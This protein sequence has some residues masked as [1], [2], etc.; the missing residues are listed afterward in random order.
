MAKPM[1]LG[2]TEPVPAGPVEK[3]LEWQRAPAAP[4][5]VLPGGDFQAQE[6]RARQLQVN[7]G[8]A[9]D[10]HPDEAAKAL[11]YSRDRGMDFEQGEREIKLAPPPPQ[12]DWGAL[13]RDHPVLSDYLSDTGRAAAARDDVG[14]LSMLEKLFG[15]WQ[16]IGWNTVQGW[17]QGRQTVRLAEIGAREADGT[18][19]PAEIAEADR[20]EKMGVQTVDQGFVPGIPGAAAQA[21]P[22][23]IDTFLKSGKEVSVGA[24][25]GVVAGAIAG[26]PAGGVGAIPG[27]A[28][29][30]LSGAGLGAKVGMTTAMGR[31]E[32]GL[33]FREYKQIPGVDLNTAR[34]A[35]NVVGAINGLLEVLP[36][37]KVLQ[38]PGLKSLFSGAGPRDW[39]R[40]LVTSNTGR[41]AVVRAAMRISEGALIDGI[42]EA[43]QEFTTML[44]GKYAGD[45]TP[46][47]PKR[48]WDSFVGGAQMAIGL[49]AAGVYTGYRGEKAEAKAGSDRKGFFEAIGQL[50]TDSKLRERMPE[51]YKAYANSLISE[52]GKIDEA[53]APAGKLRE[54]FQKEGISDEELA[55]TMPEVARQ[56]AE[57]SDPEA[58]ITIPMAD[59][60]TNI[61][62]LKGYATLHEDLR[63]KEEPTAREQKE[64]KAEVDKMLQE[65]KKPQAENGP[66]PLPGEKVFNDLYTKAI[67]SGISERSATVYA[68][69]WR[70]FAETRAAK[71]GKNAF[72]YY[73]SRKLEITNSDVI[74]NVIPEDTKFTP[75]QEKLKAAALNGDVQAL[76]KLIEPFMIDPLTGANTKE[77]WNRFAPQDD[78]GEFVNPP[79]GAYISIDANDLKRVNDT[80]GGHGAGNAFLK[81]LAAAVGPAVRENRGKF[82]RSGGDEFMAHFRTPAEA[83]KAEAAIRAAMAAA[84]SLKLEGGEHR[85]SVTLGVGADPKSADA[86]GV[87]A[88]EEA[89]AAGRSGFGRPGAVEKADYTKGDVFSRF[90]EKSLQAFEAALTAGG[91][92]ELHQ[93]VDPTETPAF[94]KWFKKSKVVDADGNPLIV[95]HGTTHGFD[96]FTKDRGNP[97]NWYGRA[98]YFTDSVED[99]NANYA[100]EGPD[101]TNRI[102]QRAEQIANER[103]VQV[104]SDEFDAITEEARKEL[105]GE[106][107]SV[108][109]VYV[110][111]QNPVIV[112]SRES[113]N[114]S[115]HKTTQLE[116]TEKFEEGYED[117]PVYEGSGM[118]VVEAI[119]K[120]GLQYRMDGPEEL[121]NDIFMKIFEGDGSAYEIEKFLRESEKVTYLEGEEGG[122]VGNEFIRDVWEAA[123]FDGAIMGA[124][125]NFGA[126]RGAGK[127]MEGINED[128][129]HY[130]AFKPT[131]IK[132]AIGNSGK[133]SSRSSNILKQK[134]EEV[135]RGKINFDDARRWF[136]ITLTG[137]ANLSTFLHESGHAFLEFLRVDAQEGD[138]ASKSELDVIAKWL[139]KENID[140]LS[141]DDLEK[142]ARG[143]ESYLMEGKAPSTKLGEVF[144]T[145]SD[146][147][148]YIY[149]TLTGLN[150]E[151]TDEVRGVFDRMLATEEEITTARESM[152][153]VPDPELTKEKSGYAE[154]FSKAMAGAQ[155]EASQAAARELRRNLTDEY[156]QIVDDVREMVKGDRAYN[157]WE[158]LSG[159]PRLDGSEFVAPETLQGKRKL[160]RA[161][162]TE[163]GLSSEENRRIRTLTE[164]GGI[165]PESIAPMLGYSSGEE[166]V[167]ELAGL[168]GRARFEKAEADR[169]MA[170]RYPAY[171]GKDVRAWIARKARTVL[172]A[173]PITRLLWDEATAAGEAVYTKG[174]AE[175]DRQ[176][177]RA[178]AKSEKEMQKANETINDLTNVQGE[179]RAALGVGA[180]IRKAKAVL[181]EYTRR[182]VSEM[183]YL[184]MQPG[185]F[186][187]AEARHAAEWVKAAKKG[188][189]AAAYEAKMEQIRNHLMWKATERALEEI[190]AISNRMRKIQ[191][192][193]AQRK[194]GKAGSQYREGVNAILEG[195]EFT[196]KSQAAVDRQISLEMFVKQMED[197]GAVINIPPEIRA[198]VGLKNY[199]RM[200]L[201]ELRAISDS[202]ANIEA[203]ARLKN[204]LFDGRQ[205][206]DFA[207]TSTKLAE[208]IKA[209]VGAEYGDKPGQKQNPGWWEEKRGFFRTA[210]ANLLKIEFLARHLDGGETAGW[211]HELLFQPLVDAQNRKRK[212]QK[213]ITQRITAPFHE[214]S[215]AD[216]MRYDRYVDFL[217]YKLRVRE[218]I[219]LMLNLG[220]EGNR[221]KIIDG[222]RYRGWTE[223]AIFKKL[224]E[225]HAAG[226]ITNKDL[227]LVEHIW[228][229]IDE[230]WPHI[231]AL[232]ERVTGV[233]PPRVEPLAFEIA[234]RTMKGGY[235]PIVYD[236][237]KSHKG[238][239][240]AQRKTGDLFENNFLLPAVEKGFTESRT[241]F[242]APIALTLDVVP[243]HV[244]EVIH[245]LTHYEAVRAV[246]RLTSSKVVREA[247]TEGVG[248]E[249]YN[250][251]RPWLQ[252]IAADGAIHENVDFVDRTLRRLRLGSSIAILGFKVTTG[253]KQ[254]YGLSTTTKEIGIKYTGVGIEQFMDRLMKGEPFKEIA[255]LSQE[256]ADLEMQHDRDIGQMFERYT[257]AFSEFGHMKHQLARFSLSWMMLN[258]KV[259]NAVT[260][261]GAREKATVEGHPDPVRYADAIVRMSQ[262]GGGVKDLAQIQRGSETKRMFV[263]MY[264]YFSVLANQLGEPL[265]RTA[266]A[267]RKATIMAARW[268]WLVTLPVLLDLGKKALPK[269]D[270]DPEDYALRM[271]RE[272]ALYAGRTTPLFGEALD[273]AFSEREARYGAW[274]ATMIKGAAAA[275]KSGRAASLTDTGV[276]SMV[277]LLGAAGGLPTGAAMNAYRFLDEYT[278]GS[279]EEPVQDI[280]FRSPSEWE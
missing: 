75:E 177:K 32:K 231:K 268:W 92:K 127:P 130:I 96:S 275:G 230:L 9:F 269:D 262:S 193:S 70:A 245:Y 69:V 86:A 68:H 113:E 10:R 73:S 100:G 261:L 143:F 238:E 81:Q 151:L 139:G 145:V 11:R 250:S 227:D 273:A 225:L 247:L 35:A 278:R 263:V 72:D 117:E 160:S 162:V 34:A 195:V 59:L 118:K 94:K 223:E 2:V 159:R 242:A 107:P 45:Q 91:G 93:K 216:R 229:T 39:V 8:F 265:P 178:A 277:E 147:M 97:E 136:R 121:A 26:A 258:Q 89:R 164:E 253:L 190:D 180:E 48:V 30:L 235:Y 168:Q 101:L 259:V 271:L 183:S 206:R 187:R 233:A 211:T 174:L 80:L 62:P 111:L 150:V 126:G 276:R 71:L 213:E 66:P 110:A 21:L 175:K 184:E 18:A 228:K 40:K 200:T 140:E 270:E 156:K 54:L 131:Q 102:V 221:T 199:K 60:A 207:I 56:L 198:G 182:R 123:G 36:I 108:M 43:A 239:Q 170:L 237:E 41:A 20:L 132:S 203:Q 169:R 249:A 49:G 148:K 103:D 16:D 33:A 236:R 87:A 83:R 176:A 279:L 19:T 246:D 112:L 82:F 161:L 115:H 146:W 186:E 61:A 165:D 256:F 99:V 171:S 98:Y 209:N 267:G 6:D 7:Q 181:E 255:E 84:P 189:Y 47:D 106:A 166:M 27:A 116:I 53:K 42:Q 28:V 46:L 79:K 24:A 58:E 158:V 280:L 17:R 63:I 64:I 23:M 52:Y 15:G 109:P 128:T 224:E 31:A 3:P 217:G 179:V 85:M 196:K 212:M 167:A 226:T 197:E 210:R 266:S 76:D 133:F 192:G 194:L 232:S 55:R 65:E 88:K 122:L 264:T 260:W 51:E 251:I 129:Y 185:T 222:Y 13:V 144:R 149:R 114:F 243:Q 141:D 201:G 4:A 152:H 163:M 135:V 191:E 252:A 104:G 119:K 240:I 57:V 90:D 77:A 120:L 29:G 274:Y 142:F 95:Y 14:R 105:A 44:G 78:R 12:A 241:K 244:N 214:M 218:V 157:A 205:K 1:D 137:K 208:H 219:S 234:G 134:N 254:I 188:D 155:E 257:S 22:L 154:R 173:E 248:R 272:Q 202:V 74:E 38:I 215:L 138:A 204:K 172:H 50:A 25:A 220:N 153:L 37:E 125:E 124:W 67:N 5:E